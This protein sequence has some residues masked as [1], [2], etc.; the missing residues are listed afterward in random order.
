MG[1]CFEFLLLPFLERSVTLYFLFFLF[2]SVSNT[3]SNNEEEETRSH[4]GLKLQ[5][6]CSIM[7]PVCCS[8]NRSCLYKLRLCIIS[9]HPASLIHSWSVILNE[10]GNPLSYV[11]SRILLVSRHQRGAI[12]QQQHTPGM[13]WWQ[14][15]WMVHTWPKEC[16]CTQHPVPW[17][18]STSPSFDLTTWCKIGD[19][20]TCQTRSLSDRQAWTQLNTTILN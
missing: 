18:A 14:L 3:S 7:L 17:P 9:S 2:V 12:I 16:C 5:A 4:K 1:Q 13:F 11:Q 20:H 8:C 6:F 15:C 19:A 10:K